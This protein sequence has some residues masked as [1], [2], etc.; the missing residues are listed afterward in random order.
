MLYIE[1][2]PSPP[3]AGIIRSL[4][5]ARA[6]ELSPARERVLPNGC[7]QF[8]IT[9]AADHLTDCIPD[10]SAAALKPIPPAIV[11]GPRLRYEVIHNRDLAELVGIIFRPGGLG[12]FLRHPVDTFFEQSIALDSLWQQN[13]LRERLQECTSPTA[14]LRKMDSLLIES[15]NGR[16]MQRRTV[17]QA[18]LHSLRRESVRDTA[19]T[20]GVSE[21]RLHQIFREDVGVSPKSWSRIHRFQR[22]LR[23]LHHGTELPWDHL[24]LDCGYYDQAH[25]ANDFHS[26]S[27]VNPSTYTALRGQW[28]NHIPF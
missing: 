2:K 7:T 28:T 14:K 20:L 8:I 9:L 13:T 12:P 5:Y 3:L 11:T 17:V 4:W 10:G 21:R 26:F 16:A 18:A 24:A 19:A 27:G 1:S 15:L 25:F 6:P 23:A 22:A